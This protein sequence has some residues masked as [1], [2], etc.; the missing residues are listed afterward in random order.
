MAGTSRQNT[1]APSAATVVCRCGRRGDTATRQRGDSWGAASV[2]GRDLL[3]PVVA[4]ALTF[5]VMAR[6]AVAQPA[7]VVAELEGRA[8]IGR[9]GTWTTANIGLPVEVGDTLRTG[10]PGRLRVVFADESVTVLGDDSQLVIDDHVFA[11]DRGVFRSVLRMISGR[12]RTL[13]SDYYQ[14]PGAVYQVET[15]TAVAGVRG[16][17]FVVTSIGDVT[18]VVGVS[19]VVEVH[20]LLDRKKGGVLITAQ[21]VTLVAPGR[22]PTPPRRLGEDRFFHYIEGLAFVGA[23]RAESRTRHDPLV[24]GAA[25]PEPDRAGVVAAQATGAAPKAAERRREP[26]E[27]GTLVGESPAV[28]KALAGKLRVEF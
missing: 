3:A 25:V 27:P 10:R 6:A 15:V 7:G 1:T 28:V 19:G 24:A 12:V 22:S 20:N 9:A 21:Q 8:E 5:L 18:E 11:P 23:G 13:A 16:T 2:N 14:R 4:V 26:L 17:E